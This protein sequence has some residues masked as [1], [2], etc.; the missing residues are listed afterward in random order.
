MIVID[1]LPNFRPLYLKPPLRRLRPIRPS[2]KSNGMLTMSKLP[3]LGLAA[4]FVL[5]ATVALGQPKPKGPKSLADYKATKV[6]G[7]FEGV[8]GPYM[9]VKNATGHPYIIA[10]QANVSKVGIVGTARPDFLKP[11]MLVSFTADI[12]KKGAVAEP[13]SELAIVAPSETNTPGLFPED[14]ENKDSTRFFVRGTVRTV[15][16]GKLTVSAGGKQ[17]A[18]ELPDDATITLESNDLSL[19][20]QGDEVSVEGRLVSEYKSEGNNVIPGKV[21]GEKI[22]IKLSEPL[23]K[24]SF[25]KKSRSS[26]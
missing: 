4:C 16:E 17:V 6:T 15:K 26:R 24:D 8:Q 25:K 14:R 7:T 10:L 22:D 11:G 21:F 18:G 19:A 3:R 9:Q 1:C 23:D 5:S 20:Q 12:D 2:S 13:I